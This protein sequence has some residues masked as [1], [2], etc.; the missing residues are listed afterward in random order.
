MSDLRPMLAVA[1]DRLPADESDWAFELKWDGVRVV[2]NVD[3]TDVRLTGRSGAD[4]TV[5]YPELAGLSAATAGLRLVLDG[6]VVVLDSS[7]RA[8]FESLAPRMQVKSA[9]KARAFARST[10]VTYIIFDVLEI[11]GESTVGLP[12]VQRRELLESLELSGAHWQL[13]PSVIGGGADMLEASRRMGIEGVVAKRLA[14]PYR[15]GR[16]SDEWI[17]VK[18]I[19]T[20]DV[21]IGGYT[22]GDGRRASTFGALLLGIPGPD[23]LAYVGSVGTGF[24]GRALDD[25]THRLA[26]LATSQTPF[27]GPVD[28]RQA[29]SARWVRPEMVGEVAFVEWTGDGRMRHPTWRGLRPDKSPAD[30]TREPFPNDHAG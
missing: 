10:P 27:A 4:M 21:V 11:N 12:Y 28:P 1:S 20:Q 17:K 23:G 16:R 15:P 5:A 2:A 19:H 24:D 22:V 14:S 18:N 3:A 30:V 29:R 9:D 7:G 6:E 13:S 8:S 25:L 26:E